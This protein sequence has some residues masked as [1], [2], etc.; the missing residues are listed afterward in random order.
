[1]T[2]K[3]QE[4]VEADRSKSLFQQES[5]RLLQHLEPFKPETKTGN[6]FLKCPVF[7]F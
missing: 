1:M 4:A 7:Y 5:F 2:T 3:T 6:N